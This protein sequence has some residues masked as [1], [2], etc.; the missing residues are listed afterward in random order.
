M[1]SLHRTTIYK[2][3]N[4]CAAPPLSQPTAGRHICKK[5]KTAHHSVHRLTLAIIH[6]TMKS[7]WKLAVLACLLLFSSCV[8]QD[9]PTCNGIPYNR[10]FQICCDGVLSFG[11]SFIRKC[12]GQKS[13]WPV[14][15]ICCNGTISAGNEA[16][17]RCCGEKPYNPLIN[18]CCPGDVIKPIVSIC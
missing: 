1:D 17:L 2:W 5:Q 3:I 11:S 8:A 7:F 16:L 12:C 9:A 13:Y 18:K 15:R 14:I 4:I 10:L 6:I